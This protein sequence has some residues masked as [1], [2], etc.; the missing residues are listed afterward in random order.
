MPGTKSIC[1]SV[2]YTA[3]CLSFDCQLG[4]SRRRRRKSLLKMKRKKMRRL[5][6]KKTKMVLAKM[7]SVKSSV[8]TI[9]SVVSVVACFVTWL[10]AARCVV[11]LRL[12]VVGRPRMVWFSWLFI[13]LVMDHYWIAY[14]LLCPFI[15]DCNC[16]HCQ[17]LRSDRFGR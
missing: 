11:S 1:S 5:R 9:T 14:L 8:Q 16:C 6:E 10:T 3:Y 2:G 15:V 4:E 12:E 7:I 17:R 13:Y